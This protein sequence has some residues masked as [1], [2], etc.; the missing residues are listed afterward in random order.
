[1]PHMTGTY[2]C[3]CEYSLKAMFPTPGFWNSSQKSPAGK[4]GGY[5]LDISQYLLLEIKLQVE[6]L[7]SI[8]SIQFF[9]YRLFWN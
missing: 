7:L 1:M 6:S 9:H 3:V 5:V 2:W 4:N 8:T